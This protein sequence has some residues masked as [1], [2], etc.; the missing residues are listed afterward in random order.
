L[1]LDQSRWISQ[2]EV[3]RDLLIQDGKL[4][5]IDEMRR[6]KINGSIQAHEQKSASNPTP[7]RIQGNGTINGQPF[8]LHVGGGPLL[9]LDPEHP[10]S[11][12]LHI[13]AG[14]L[15]ANSKGRA[16]KPFDLGQLDLK[17]T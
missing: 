7:F 14:N 15:Q 9:N 11:F 10:Y 1:A 4:T 6:L 8:E 17:W 16:L 13:V 5:L 3:V 2:T 12:D